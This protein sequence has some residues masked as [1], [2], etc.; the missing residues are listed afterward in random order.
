[1][2]ISFLCQKF[3]KVFSLA[4]ILDSLAFYLNLRLQTVW[5]LVDF[6]ALTRISTNVMRILNSSNCQKSQI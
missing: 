2:L 5:S 6:I 1:M 3:V 4:N